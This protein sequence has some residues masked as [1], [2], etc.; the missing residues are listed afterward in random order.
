MR[1]KAKKICPLIVIYK[2]NSSEELHYESVFIV[3]IR[4][5]TIYRAKEIKSILLLPISHDKS[6]YI[7]HQFFSLPSLTQ[8]LS[9]SFSLSL[10]LFL[11]LVLFPHTVK[12]KK[13]A[14]LKVTR[15]H[16]LV[17]VS[18]SNYYRHRK[19]NCHII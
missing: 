9:L 17:C 2:V 1:K 11:F 7:Y 8:E 14:L 16:C 10:S 5:L 4:P 3:C 6:V 12:Y 13:S 18:T 15:A 19:K